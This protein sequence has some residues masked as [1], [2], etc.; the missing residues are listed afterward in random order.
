MHR[1][2]RL[3]AASDRP[4][5]AKSTVPDKSDVASHRTTQHGHRYLYIILQSHRPP[6]PDTDARRPATY[7]RDA[8]QRVARRP[9][10]Y[11]YARTHSPPIR[12]VPCVMLR[13]QQIVTRYIV[14]FLSISL[15]VILHKLS[16]LV[17]CNRTKSK[18]F[19]K[20]G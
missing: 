18:K 20:R 13:L 11:I 5:T 19:A 12:P 10:T 7:H 4:K 9:S 2:S 15:V 3:K 8:R 6:L 17:L 14:I 1:L 16:R